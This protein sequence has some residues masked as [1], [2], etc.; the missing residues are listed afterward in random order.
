M[1]NEKPITAGKFEMFI[2]GSIFGFVLA[3][4]VLIVSEHMHSIKYPKMQGNY[5]M[6]ILQIDG[7]NDTLEFNIENNFENTKK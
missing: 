3:I 4:A 1:E 2:F 5:R 7:N 6:I